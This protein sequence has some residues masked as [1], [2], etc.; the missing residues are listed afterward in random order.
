[1]RGIQEQHICENPTFPLL[2]CWRLCRESTRLRYV[3]NQFISQLR[4]RQSAQ[5]G[6]H[7]VSMAYFRQIS[8]KSLSNWTLNFLNTKFVWMGLDW[9]E[10]TKFFGANLRTIS[11]LQVDRGYPWRSLRGLSFEAVYYECFVKT[12]LPRPS[13]KNFWLVQTLHFHIKVQ[14]KRTV[15]GPLPW[16]KKISRRKARKRLKPYI[17]RK[18]VLHNLEIQYVK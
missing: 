12:F 7:P 4:L 10:G 15:W 1:M 18:R 13:E 3:L 11:H 9:F 17:N 5:D 14:Y 8:D 6:F 16:K 2:S